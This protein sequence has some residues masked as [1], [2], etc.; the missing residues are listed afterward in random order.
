MR[1]L[2]HPDDDPTA[3]ARLGRFRAQELEVA[4]WPALNRD[5]ATD[6]GRVPS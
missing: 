4:A 1:L 3:D 5:G 2:G 6:N